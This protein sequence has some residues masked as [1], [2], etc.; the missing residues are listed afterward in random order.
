MSGFFGVGRGVVAQ[1]LWAEIAPTGAGSPDAREGGVRHRHVGPVKTAAV[2]LAAVLAMGSAPAA[3]LVDI[4]HD[5]KAPEKRQA[6]KFQ[7]LDVL[8][9]EVPN[10]PRAVV[11]FTELDAKRG[12]YRWRCR[13]P[14]SGEVVSGVG[15]V[16]E[17]YEEI[18][19]GP[20]RGHVLPLPG[21][22]TIVRAGDIRAAWSWADDRVA[23]LYYYARRAKVTILGPASFA[24]EP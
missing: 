24:N 21:N 3:Q 23:Y 7:A 12:S 15:T 1:A 14:G 11:Q 18:P 17:K 10:G 9:I 19:D 2:W 8:L 5:V 13:R 22:D 6:V 4:S 16:V 20:G